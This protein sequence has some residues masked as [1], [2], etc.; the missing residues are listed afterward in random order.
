MFRVGVAR[1]RLVE[2]DGNGNIVD[3][4]ANNGRRHRFALLLILLVGRT[5]DLIL[6]FMAKS[7]RQRQ[8]QQHARVRT[9]VQDSCTHFSMI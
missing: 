3:H 2:L 1:G 8:V 6:T 7:D 4:V 9:N 5:R